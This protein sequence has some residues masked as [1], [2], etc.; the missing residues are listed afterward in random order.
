MRHGDAVLALHHQLRLREAGLQVASGQ[1]H[2]RGDVAG[3][4]RLL[5]QVLGE[6]VF[7]EQRSVRGHRLQNVKHR[8][9]DFVLHL[10]GLQGL[11]GNFQGGGRHRRHRMAVVE[12][13]VPGHDVVR[14]IHQVPAGLADGH[15]A[16]DA[17]E[18]RAGD[19]R[20]DSVH[21]QRLG[22]VHPLDAGVG[23]GAAQDLAMQH[24]RKVLVGAELRPAGHLVHPVRAHRTGSQNLIVHGFR[25]FQPPCWIN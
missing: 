25:H 17:G 8:R 23:V 20:A 14:D 16:G 10:D 12:S 19:R 21:G 1:S 18:V 5:R 6:A 13:L 3:L 7:V 4:V 15:A 22:Q 11:L 24:V 9:Q 2:H